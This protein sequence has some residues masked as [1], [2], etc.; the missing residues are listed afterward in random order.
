MLSCNINIDHET[1]G[2]C[3]CEPLQPS[4]SSHLQMLFKIGC[5]KNLVISIGNTCS[6]VSFYKTAGLKAYNFIKKRPQHRCFPVSIAKFLR[7]PFFYRTLV[8]ASAKPTTSQE[9]HLGCLFF[10]I[11]LRAV[12]LDPKLIQNIAQIIL[13]YHTTKISSLN[14]LF[15]CFQFQ[16][17]F[18]RNI[19]VFRFWWK[20]YAKL[21]TNNYVISL[22]KKLSLLALCLHFAV[23]QELSVL[24]Y[25]FENGI[26][27]CKQKY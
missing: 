3:N 14:C 17:V 8:A 1:L 5:L 4:R 27:S 24:R 2:P 20:T 15:I 13:Y 9:S 18:W 11:A 10:N 25:N 26:M 6:G 22:V 16:N 21:W 23:D 19:S 12:D 7:T